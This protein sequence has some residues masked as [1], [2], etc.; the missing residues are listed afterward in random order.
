MHIWNNLFI[1]NHWALGF[2]QEVMNGAIYRP[3]GV[4]PHQCWSETNIL[5]P[6]ITGMVGWKPNALDSSA[7]LRPRFPMSWDTVSVANLR[8]GKSLVR[9]SMKRGIQSTTYLCE[10][11]SGPPITLHVAPEIPLGM[12]ITRAL[13]AGNPVPVVNATERGALAVPISFRLL[14]RTE[15]VLNHTGGVG[16][17][18]VTPTPAPGDSSL[19]YRIV[20]TTLDGNRYVIAVEG[21]SG[22]ETTFGVRTFDRKISTAIGADVELSQRPGA[23]LLRVRFEKSAARFVRKTITLNF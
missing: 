2:V 8:V 1:K 22:S 11:L 6:A 4:C 13:V 7:L 23:A 10:L 16:M 20:S 19:G 18:P 3:S 15:V 17:M 21:R 9:F 12:T 5:H 14:Q